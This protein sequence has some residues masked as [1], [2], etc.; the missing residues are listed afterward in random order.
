MNT[1]VRVLADGTRVIVLANRDGPVANKLAST[2]S[3]L[4]AD[5]EGKTPL[6][7]RGSMNDWGDQMPLSKHRDGRYVIEGPIPKGDYEFK[8][9]SADWATVDLGA[10]PDGAGNLP[11]LSPGGTLPLEFGGGNIKLSLP[12]D[13]S[14]R[15]TLTGLAQG[16]PVVKVETV[17]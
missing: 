3:Y 14:Y 13:G 5:P 16:V 15:L 10:A 8:L 11:T 1:D 4:I 2:Y 9:A 17:E 6:L 12:A 7:L